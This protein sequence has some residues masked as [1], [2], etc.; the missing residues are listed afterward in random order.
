MRLE[1]RRQIERLLARRCNHDLVAQIRQGLTQD[2]RAGG[3]IFDN[4]NFLSHC[5][6]SEFVEDVHAPCPMNDTGTIKKRATPSF[7]FKSD[8]TTVS[9][10]AG[11]K[12]SEAPG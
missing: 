7:L 2:V 8:R 12:P 1:F 3:V 6:P 10:C 11:A 9:A 5:T 4:K